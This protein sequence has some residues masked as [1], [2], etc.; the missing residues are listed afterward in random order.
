MALLSNLINEELTETHDRRTFENGGSVTYVTWEFDGI[1]MGHGTSCYPGNSIIS[2]GNDNNVIRLHFGL[3]GNY[4]FTFRELGRGFDLIGGH[5]NMLFSEGFHMDVENKTMQI[6]TF[7]VQFPKDMFI[8][9][10]AGGSERMDRF[11]EA[12]LMG[13]PAILSDDWGALSPVIE[14]TI[15]EVI[16]CQYVG[17]VKRQFMLSKALELM[18][19]SAESFEKRHSDATRLITSKSDQERIIAARDL[20]NDR[21]DHPPSLTEI[22]RQVCLNEYKLKRGFREMFDHSV[23]GYLADQRLNLAR[24]IL[25][26]TQRT[27]ADISVQLGYSTPQHFSNAFRRKFGITPMQVRDI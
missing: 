20:I 17:G 24:R 22:A 4:R 15:R 23:F 8:S 11:C 16:G 21:L 12:I 10:A 18:M 14:H 9:C 13:R 7:G 2:T 1:R 27:A 3:R 25:Q 26:D 19:L 5:H 6:E